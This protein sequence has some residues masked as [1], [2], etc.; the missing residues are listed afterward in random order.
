MTVPVVPKLPAPVELPAGA[1]VL[2]AARPVP[3]AT[4]IPVLV[5]AAGYLVRPTCPKTSML[6]VRAMA[7]LRLILIYHLIFTYLDLSTMHL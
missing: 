6:V 1:D 3:P 5:L 4:G 2:P 7:M